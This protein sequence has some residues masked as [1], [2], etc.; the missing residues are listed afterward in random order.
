LSFAFTL[1][2][3]S[4]T[5]DAIQ[6]GLEM[7]NN[8][9]VGFEVQAV[10]LHLAV[11][12]AQGKL[13]GGILA[14]TYTDTLRIETVWLDKSLRGQGQ[15]KAMMDAVEAEGRR[16][17]ARHAWL[18][19]LSWQARPFYEKLGYHVFGEMP[20]MAGRHRRYFMQKAL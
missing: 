3:S 17:G 2:D 12:D 10:P 13:C 18:V 14:L 7:H 1:D 6:R 8:E 16:R 20:I 11:R 15:G 9:A 19:T 4:E 5:A